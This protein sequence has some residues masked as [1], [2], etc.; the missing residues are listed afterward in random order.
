MFGQ[1]VQHPDLPGDAG[2]P[3]PAQYQRIPVDTHT[4][5]PSTRMPVPTAVDRL[6]AHPAEALFRRPGTRC[7]GGG[8]VR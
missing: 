4:G 8:I 3:A 2:D 7:M 6:P 1:A 5:D